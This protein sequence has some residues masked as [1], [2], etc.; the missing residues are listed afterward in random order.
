MKR[1]LF[2]LGGAVLALRFIWLF[3]IP[4][5]SHITTDFPI[6]YTAAWAVRHGQPLVDLYDPY[7]FNAMTQRAGMDNTLSVFGVYPP[8][9]ALL[10]WPFASVPPQ[11]A[12]QICSGRSRPCRRRPPSRS[13]PR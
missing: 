9:S 1:F 5:W 13:G 4:G 11:A 7:W 8:F 6:Y 10:L 12:K 2:M 3:V